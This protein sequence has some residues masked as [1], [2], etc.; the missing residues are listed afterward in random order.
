MGTGLPSLPLYA[1]TVLSSVRSHLSCMVLRQPMALRG[2]Q[3]GPTRACLS[4][5]ACN[6]LENKCWCLVVCAAC[7]ASCKAPCAG[8][9]DVPRDCACGPTPMHMASGRRGMAA[10]CRATANHFR[11]RGAPGVGAGKCELQSACSGCCGGLKVCMLGSSSQAAWRTAVPGRSHA[12]QGVVGAAP[13][14]SLPPQLG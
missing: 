7:L 3:G 12:A 5:A 8:G 9:L 13:P 2:R 14:C 6:V 11:W 1:V 4:S 10:H